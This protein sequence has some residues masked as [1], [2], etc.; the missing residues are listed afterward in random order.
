MKNRKIKSAP[1]YLSWILI[2][3]SLSIIGFLS[4]RTFP[5]FIHFVG[6]N[7]SAPIF[8][9]SEITS[10]LAS[11]VLLLTAR[12]I[13]LRRR[14][15]W[16]AAT[17]LQGVLILNSLVHGIFQLLLRH[18][19]ETI[20]FQSIGISHIFS[21]LVIFLLLIYCR[22]EF[23]TKSDMQTFLKTFIFFLKISAIS[24]FV[25]LSFVG[26]DKRSFI[27][28]PSFA[29]ILEI[30][31]K[32]LF[33]I[34]GSVPYVSERAQNRIEYTLASLGLL[35]AVSLCWQLFKP[36]QYKS[37]IDLQ[38]LAEIRNLLHRYPDHDSL[39]YF[40]LRENKSFV[41]SKNLKATIPYSVI[42]GVM[43]TTGDP[44]GDK[45]SWPS[46]ISKFCEEAESHA[47]IPAIY[48]CTEEA[49]L[50]WRRETGFESLEMGDEAVVMVDTFTLEG[51]E[52][53]NV[54]QMV[55][56]IKRKDY[57]ILIRKVSEIEPDER[58]NLSRLADKWRRGG[59]ER[60]FSMAL[61]R[62]CDPSDP[63]LVIAIAIQ[64]G[65]PKGMLQ[66][67]PWGSAGLSLDSMRRSPDCDPGINEL[68][69]SETIAYAKTNGFEKIS[70][71]FATFRSIFEKGERLGA[72]PITRLSHRLL[73]FMSRFFQ[74]ESL[75]RFNAKFRPIWS[76]RYILFPSIGK[77]AR[78][79]LAILVI[80]SFV[81][82]PKPFSTIKAS[83]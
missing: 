56:Q 23:K 11:T 48:G 52:M 75:Y 21:E 22:Q 14:R 27:S 70:L 76:P 28:V 60:G 77:L 5:H 8:R 47:W 1:L 38:S 9:G 19:D 50:I 13:R 25:G 81:T 67:I 43:V 79:A 65:E 58:Q 72:G 66:F 44:I 61:G 6:T 34:S 26:L 62:F 49:G 12:S 37:K 39:S 10:V 33:G 69:I 20:V 3:Q 29:Q 53:K 80:E 18:K 15:A 57:S 46:A 16:I 36:N 32:G 55:N 54:R 40:A 74:M 31:L 4:T 17:I 2:V 41:W 63:T 68:L 82:L 51:P 7:L 71:N 35:I 45:E 59:S 83:A 42:N 73:I 64:H 78:V 24:F 30:T